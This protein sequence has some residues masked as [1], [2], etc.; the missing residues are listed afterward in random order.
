[1]NFQ[2]LIARACLGACCLAVHVGGMAQSA[3]SSSSTP[4][5]GVRSEGSLK[6]QDP[7]PLPPMYTLHDY[8][9]ASKFSTAMMLAAPARRAVAEYHA[10]HEGKWPASNR[11]AEFKPLLEER[12]AVRDVAISAGGTITVVFNDLVPE[13]SG[14]S[15]VLAPVVADDGMVQ[16]ICSAPEIPR[17]YR[18]RACP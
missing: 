10:D 17:I 12:F 4:A 15:A 6:A 18:R 8:Q 3:A 7:S 11:D 1:M 13:L 9:V 14:K 16:F 5:G 2:S